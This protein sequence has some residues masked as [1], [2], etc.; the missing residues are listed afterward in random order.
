M[1]ENSKVFIIMPG[2]SRHLAVFAMFR[3]VLKKT[4]TFSWDLYVRLT[5][6]YFDFFDTAM[7]YLG[8]I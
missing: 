3:F 7:G 2:Q 5:A 4:N 6:I 1:V 8:Y